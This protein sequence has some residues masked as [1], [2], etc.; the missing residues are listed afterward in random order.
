ML[1]KNA[2]LELYVCRKKVVTKGGKSIM[3]ALMRFLLKSL[4]ECRFFCIG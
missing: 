2:D 4:S 3:I 1:S